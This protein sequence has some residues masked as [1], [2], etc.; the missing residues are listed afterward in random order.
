MS[1]ISKLLL[2]AITISVFA[3]FIGAVQ[4]KTQLVCETAQRRLTR[5]EI[6]AYIIDRTINR[7][8]VFVD[9]DPAIYSLIVKRHVPYKDMHQFRIL[10]PRCCKLSDHGSDGSVT[11]ADILFSR[12]AYWANLEYKVF[13]LDS[14]N[15]IK[16]VNVKESYPIDRC[17]RPSI[18]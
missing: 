1:G 5:A 7:Q 14:T 15:Q 10:N 8:P 18:D 9:I 6:E 4:I 3:L 16:S 13:Y 2:T 11:Y 17:G 12:T